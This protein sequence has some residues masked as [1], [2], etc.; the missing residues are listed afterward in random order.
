MKLHNPHWK[1]L[2]LCWV[3]GFRLLGGL[4]PDFPAITTHTY[5]PSAIS[6]GAV[7]LATCPNANVLAGTPTYLMVLNNDG[8]PLA[9]KQIGYQ[10]PGDY[11]AADFKQLPDGT[12]F[13]QQFMSYLTYTGGGNTYGVQM[14]DN[15][16]EITRFQMGNGYVAESHDFQLLP[17][18]HALMM[19]YCTTFRDLSSVVPGGYPRAEVSGTVVQ[20]LNA[21]RQ[22]IWQ[23]RSWDH[24]AN[25]QYFWGTT[26]GGSLVSAWHENVLR[27]DDDGDLFIGTV[28]E[29]MKVSR[30]TGNVLWRLG[31]PFNQ[32]TFLGV[33]EQEGV[34]AFLGHDFHRLP[35]GNVL[36][37]NNTAPNRSSRAQEYKLDEVNK[38]ATYVWSYVPTNYISASARGS[39]ER[40]ANGNTLIGWG[41]SLVPGYT[42]PDVT[43]VAPDG[44]KVW[45]LQFNDPTV[46]SYRAFRIPYPA[47][48][49]RTFVLNPDIGNGGH[50][51]FATGNSDTGVT[52]DVDQQVSQGYNS[53]TV[54]R[55]PF[56]PLAPDF[57]GKAPRLLP[58][59]VQFVPVGLDAISG[60]VSFNVASFQLKNPAAT[61]VY[62]RPNIG[63]GL[64]IPLQTTYNFATGQL[65]ASTT[66]FGEYALG[67]PDIA[68]VPYPPLLDI[69]TTLVTNQFI[70]RVTDPVQ[71][72]TN[73]SVNQSLPILLAWSPKGFAASYHFQLSRDPAFGS[74]DVDVPYLTDALYQLTNAAAGTTYYWRVNT[75]N[76]GGISDWASSS[77]MTVPPAITAIYPTNGAALQ[78][79]ISYFLQWNDNGVENV[80]LD[81]YKGGA[82]VKNI[83]TASSLVS[84]KWLASLTATPG[85][86]YSVKIT[87]TNNP[88]INAFSGT[89]SLIDP[90]AVDPSS[91]VRNGNG[92]IQFTV[93]VS[94]V[95]TAT[96]Y[97]SSDLKSWMPLQT[98]SFQNGRAVFIDPSASGFPGRAYR[99]QVP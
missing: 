86:D 69:P 29:I 43:E 10:T 45:E 1:S 88:A 22:V 80:S 39:A 96:V 99:V 49:Q 85:N 33:P 15:L 17:N 2:G 28:Q 32:F 74:T 87:S 3:T 79:G 59:R 50:Y 51:V 83:T 57:V 58:V 81:L 77:F 37:Y 23:W 27:Q 82:F 38:V 62:F 95:P 92:S 52:L 91:V 24:F 46:D 63:Q 94:G 98:V 5:N 6:P 71:A 26:S 75:S 93:T 67:F 60:T 76:D 42:G 12:L 19:G 53:L 89:F 64:F 4:P 31:G 11:Y 97:E 7:L 34:L 70:T 13:Y 14:D 9:Y 21:Q 90:P 36:L 16:N 30:Q 65:L 25:N 41:T 35:N 47:A 84:Y 61:T 55:Q 78:R 66:D 8:T 18:G 54:V 72:G 48:A 68:E 20:E 40:L 44:S 73:Y 56:A